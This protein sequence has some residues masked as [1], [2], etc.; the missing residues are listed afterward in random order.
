M[1]EVLRNPDGTQ[2]VYVDS[3]ELDKILKDAGVEELL[4]SITTEGDNAT[5]IAIAQ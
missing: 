2:S 5:A 3:E 1:V 4:V